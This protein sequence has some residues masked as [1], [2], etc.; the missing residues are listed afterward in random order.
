MLT[1]RFSSSDPIVAQILA[2][3]ESQ[4]V[5]QAQF[6]TN[7]VDTETMGVDVVAAY[8]TDVGDGRLTITG[9]GNITKTEVQDTNIPQEMANIFTDGDLDAVRNTLFNREERNRLEDALPRQKGNISIKFERSTFHMTARANFFGDVKYKPTNNANDETFG[10]KVLFDLNVSI[11]VMPGTTV[12][13][14]AN[15]LLNT[16][17]DKHCNGLASPQNTCGNYSDGRFPY[18]RRV[19]QFGMNGGFY[20]AR[21]GLRL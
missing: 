10:A 12:T 3:F 2:P 18:S 5:G 13:V 20:Y 17:P 15:N 14:G 1:S 8:T 9:A 7:A 4:G 19:T 21:L 6:F 11:E 16:F